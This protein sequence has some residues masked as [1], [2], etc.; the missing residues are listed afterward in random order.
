M[1]QPSYELTERTLL[2]KDGKAVP[3]GHP[4]GVVLLGAAGKRI[5]HAQAVAAGLTTDVQEGDFPQHAG[6]GYYT[7]SSGERVKGKA[8][9][10]AAEKQ[11]ATGPPQDKARGPQED[12]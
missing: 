3:A 5:S 10:V 9:A 12:K 6:G 7:L 2:D 4:S 11:L 1:A 8:A